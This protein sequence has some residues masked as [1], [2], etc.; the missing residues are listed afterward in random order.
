MKKS[1]LIALIFAFFQ[2]LQAQ[3]LPNSAKKVRPLLIGNKVPN[4]EVSLSDGKDVKTQKLFK[5]K[6][7]VLVVYRGGWCPFCNIQ[8]SGLAS[9]KNDLIDMGYQ[10][11]AVSPDSK[12]TSESQSYAKNFIIASDSSTKLIRG[13]G[14]AYQ[15]S[16]KYFRIL[17]K[18]SM[19]VNTSVIPAPS[20]FILD[21]KGEI[22]FKHVSTNF[23][24]R[25]SSELLLAIAEGYKE[26]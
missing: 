5:Q 19:G 24:K 9:V 11:V 13:L 3:N 18:A 1:I 25:L 23:K 21:S 15:A 10:I 2:T 17:S 20:V 7:T 22:L 4:V 14:I 12:S 16:K 26:I 8:L 6:Q